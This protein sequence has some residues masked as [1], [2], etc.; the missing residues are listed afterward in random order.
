MDEVKPFC[1]QISLMSKALFHFLKAEITAEF[2][3]RS[4]AGAVIMYVFAC[5]G[6]VYYSLQFNEGAGTLSPS[7]W[8]ILFWLIILFTCSGGM[9]NLLLK[10]HQNR[11]QY[12]YWAC[13]PT[14]F[15]LGKTLFNLLFAEILAM[16]AWIVLAIMTSQIQNI[17]PAFGWVVL[18]GTAGFSV[19]FTGMSAIAGRGMQNSLLAAILGFPLVIPLMIFVTRLSASVLQSGSLDGNGWRN[20]F[21]IGSFDLLLLALGL[22]LFPYIWRD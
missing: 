13:S 21:L 7:V 6:V 18:L 17:N 22:I 15:L 16:I 4:L 2:R 12:W 20:L 14:V 19:L 11:Q 8:G 9:S 10:E 1:G 3:N 5:V